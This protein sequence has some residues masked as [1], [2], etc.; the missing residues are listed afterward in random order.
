MNIH[1]VQPGETI[2]TIADSHGIS[3]ERLAAENDIIYSQ[4]LIVG[5]ALVI[6]KPRKVY[7][8]Q[9]E[10][11]LE[12]IANTQ[13]IDVMEL[14]RNNPNVS[15]RELFPGEELVISYEGEKTATVK[16]NGFA[17]PFI[18]RETL[19]KTLPYLTYLTVYSYRVKQDGNLD[20]IDDL[21]M[22]Q[23]AKNYGVAPIMFIAAPH[24]GRYVDTDI[25]HIIID[26]EEIQN[27]FI[28]NVLTMLRRKGYSGINMDTPYIQPRDR[29][30]YVNLIAKITERLNREGYLVMVTISPSTFEVSTGIIYSGVDYA[31]LSNASNAVLYQL[32]YSWGYPYSL[33]ISVLPFERV[34]QTLKEAVTLIPPEKCILDISIVG[35]LWEFPYFAAMT[36]ANFLNYHSAI[37]LAEDTNSVIQFN[38]SSCSAYFQYIENDQE[39][40]AWFKDSRVIATVLEYLQKYHIQ[41]VSLW[42][43]MYFITNIWLLINSQYVIEKV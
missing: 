3:P 28:E 16:T 33:P 30:A 27:T 14:L 42:N 37:E 31:G 20:D 13:G 23:M 34:L 43:I 24:E 19:Q 41:G 40:M 21:E 36:I 35:Y 29:E 7:I 15:N 22:I 11:T 2:H 38:E 32:T 1:I 18:D 9:E 17:Y 10:D 12:S 25:A 39:Y 4:H 26:N 6:I 5:E 8:V